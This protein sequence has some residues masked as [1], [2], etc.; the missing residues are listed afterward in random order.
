MSD[1]P[2]LRA[3]GATLAPARTRVVRRLIALLSITMS[4]PTMLVAA[5][6]TMKA[7]SAA[8]SSGSVILGEAIPNVFGSVDGNSS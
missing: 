5:L 4:D 8:T 3:R 1:N 2:S 6:E 7:T